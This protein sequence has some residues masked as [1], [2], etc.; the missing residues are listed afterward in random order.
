MQ[1]EHNDVKCAARW[2]D[3]WF[4][5]KIILLKWRNLLKF[6]NLPIMPHCLD[7]SKQRAYLFKSLCK[8]CGCKG[9]LKP[10]YWCSM[11][12]YLQIFHAVIWSLRYILEKFP[13]KQCDFVTTSV[14][15]VKWTLT[16]C[17]IPVSSNSWTPALGSAETH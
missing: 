12:H 15:I 13:K 17:T 11:L 3:S 4:Q 14:D 5:G 10:A 7:N 16:V 2:G 9:Q 6:W 1:I 8:I